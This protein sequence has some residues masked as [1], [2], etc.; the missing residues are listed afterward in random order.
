MPPVASIKVQIRSVISFKYSTNSIDKNGGGQIGTLTFEVN[1]EVVGAFSGEDKVI[2][3]VVPT[4]MSQL[5]NDSSY[6]TRDD[7]TEDLVEEIKKDIEETLEKS[8]LITIEELRSKLRG[9]SLLCALL[10]LLAPLM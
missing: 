6:I 7:I 5:T 9:T 3:I 1:D 2:D 8:R 10:K 4:K